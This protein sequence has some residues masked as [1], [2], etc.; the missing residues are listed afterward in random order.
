MQGWGV[1]VRLP[2]LVGSCLHEQ[3][4]DQNAGELERTEV[5]EI[6]QDDL[7][8]DSDSRLDFQKNSPGA[9]EAYQAQDGNL[10]SQTKWSKN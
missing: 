4:W 6:N 9:G 8:I 7:R 1:G 5:T 10:R 2:M 3:A